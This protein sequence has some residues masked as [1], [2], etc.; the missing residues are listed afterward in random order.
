MK[1]ISSPL[2][3]HHY[4]SMFLKKINIRKSILYDNKNDAV[5]L[6]FPVCTYSYLFTSKHLLCTILYM[7]LNTHLCSGGHIRKSI[8]YDNKNDAVKLRFPVCTYS[9]SFASKHLLCTI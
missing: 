5:K 7:H 2:I 3:G 4:L 6:R 9:Y 1:N 8:L